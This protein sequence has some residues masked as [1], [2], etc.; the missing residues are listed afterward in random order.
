MTLSAPRFVCGPY[1]VTPEHPAHWVRKNL[2]GESVVRTINGK[3]LVDVVHRKYEYAL[4]WDAMSKTDFDSLEELF[5]YHKDSSVPVSFLYYKWSSSASPVDCVMSMGDQGFV[6]G[7]GNALYY[8]SMTIVLT[9][10]TKRA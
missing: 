5:N 3:E 7:D 2:V 9:E 6:A 1:T 4:V 8:S 10:I